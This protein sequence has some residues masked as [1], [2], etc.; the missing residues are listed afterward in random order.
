[1]F[2]DVEVACNDYI[3]LFNWSEEAFCSKGEFSG[4]LFPSDSFNC[5]EFKSTKIIRQLIS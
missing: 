3:L 5:R 1:M 2:G 4:R